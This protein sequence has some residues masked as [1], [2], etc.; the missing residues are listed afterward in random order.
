[1]ATQIAQTLY[2]WK[3]HDH[4]EVP[5]SPIPPHNKFPMHVYRVSIAAEERALERE[6]RATTQESTIQT[7]GLSPRYIRD[8]MSHDH[9]HIY[10]IAE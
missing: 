4:D 9:T 2:S 10:A 6:F 7:G 3:R 1:M 5:T 8:I